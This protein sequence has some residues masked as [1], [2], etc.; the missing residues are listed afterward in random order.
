VKLKNGLTKPYFCD[1][2]NLSAKADNSFK[3]KQKFFLKED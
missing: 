1:I 3:T 2:I